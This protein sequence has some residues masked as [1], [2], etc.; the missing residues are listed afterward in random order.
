MLNKKFKHHSWFIKSNMTVKDFLDY[1]LSNSGDFYI[2]TKN[3]FKTNNLF[4]EPEIEYRL[5]DGRCSM[6]LEYQER[7]YL[8]E[9]NDYFKTKLPPVNKNYMMSIISANGEPIDDIHDIVYF[10]R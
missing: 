1:V 3:K 9:N 5:N 6:K 8:A 7:N 2:T 10:S 4:D